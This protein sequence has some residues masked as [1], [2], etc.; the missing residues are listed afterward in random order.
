MQTEVYGT[1][2]FAF[3]SNEISDQ[4]CHK[5]NRLFIDRNQRRNEILPRHVSRTYVD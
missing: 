5:I 3:K 2:E 4:R 1:S